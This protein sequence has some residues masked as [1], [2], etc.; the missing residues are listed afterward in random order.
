M[1]GLHFKEK[2]CTL[3]SGNIGKN[4]ILLYPPKATAETPESK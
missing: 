2:N 3:S 4:A 1:N